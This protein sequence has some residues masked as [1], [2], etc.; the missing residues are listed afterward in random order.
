MT[1]YLVSSSTESLD[2]PWWITIHDTNDWG[3]DKNYAFEHMLR[4]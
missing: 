2:I 4:K 3:D 1:E